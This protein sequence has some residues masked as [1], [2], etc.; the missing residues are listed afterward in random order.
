MSKSKY[1]NCVSKCMARKRKKIKKKK[2][3]KGRVGKSVRSFWNN[4]YS[5]VPL[6]RVKAPVYEPRHKASGR[7]AFAKLKLG[8]EIGV[9]ASGVML[10]KRVQASKYSRNR[11]VQTNK[12]G[13]SRKNTNKSGISKPRSTF[14]SSI[15]SIRKEQIEEVAKNPHP[16]SSPKQS[17]FSRRK[18][19]KS[20]I[21]KPSSKSSYKKK[22]GKFD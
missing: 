17:G 15:S 9:Q 13:F 11:G 4:V 2:K 5:E 21:S 19:K 8:S 7:E 3:V 20:G 6:Y 1:S 14:P 10:N 12:S 16:P 18:P 22:I